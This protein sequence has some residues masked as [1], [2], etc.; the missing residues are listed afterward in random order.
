VA[1]AWQS[2]LGAP[3]GCP[4]LDGPP[5]VPGAPDRLDAGKLTL[6][7]HRAA[8]DKFQDGTDLP[9][10]PWAFTDNDL[11][12]ART[13]IEFALK[14]WL[15]P[16]LVDAGFP[17]WQVVIPSANGFN[18]ADRT[19][20]TYRCNGSGL[21]TGHPFSQEPDDGWIKLDNGTSNFFLALSGTRYSPDELAQGHHATPPDENLLATMFGALPDNVGIDRAWYFEHYFEE[22]LDSGTPLTLECFPE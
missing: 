21:G 19:P 15:Y 3:A 7:G 16:P 13:G 9:T 6:V 5:Q 10:T 17:V 12:A 11:A 20:V 18:G 14:Q 2:H 8:T 4:Q 1:G 22:Q